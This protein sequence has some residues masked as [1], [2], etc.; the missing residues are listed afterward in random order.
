MG[1]YT[2]DIEAYLKRIQYDGPADLKPNLETIRRLQMCHACSI[3]FENLDVILGVP[4]GLDLSQ[5]EQKLVTENRGGYCFE[6]NSLMIA[7]LIELGFEVKALSGR[8]RIGRTREMMAPRTHLFAKVMVEGDPWL[9]DIGVGGATPTEP[10]R[11][12]T[13]EPQVTAHDT[14]RI[15]QGEDAH[16]LPRWFHQILLDDLWH[17]VCEFTGEEMPMIDREVGNWW[18]STNPESKFRQNIMAAMAVADGSRHSLSTTKYVH[19]SAGQVLEQI[20]ITT[21]KQM[22]SVLSDR[23]GIELP[24]DTVFGI[25]GL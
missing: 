13:T 12:N 8:V 15:V 10:L 5:I 6:Q 14:R 21:S 19:R 1:S 11:F 7:V 4:I 3:P 23:F 16:G 17:D 25:A 24:I 18:T 2:V 22:I 9:V 20:D